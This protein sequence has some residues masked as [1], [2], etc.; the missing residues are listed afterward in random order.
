MQKW[1]KGLKKALKGIFSTE[2]ILS[3]VPGQI[4]C[5]DGEKVSYQQCWLLICE[6]VDPCLRDGRSEDGYLYDEDMTDVFCRYCMSSSGEYFVPL[7]KQN[8]VNFLRQRNQLRIDTE[9]LDRENQVFYVAG[10]T[11]AAK[12]VDLLTDMANAVEQGLDLADLAQTFAT[13]QASIE[14]RDGYLLQ[15]SD[16]LGQPYSNYTYLA[17][18]L[19][20]DLE[21]CGDVLWLQYDDGSYLPD[22]RELSGADAGGKIFYGDILTLVKSN[23]RRHLCEEYVQELFDDISEQKK[24][25]LSSGLDKYRAAIAATGAKGAEITSTP[26]LLT[27]FDTAREVYIA[28]SICCSTR[29]EMQMQYELFGDWCECDGKVELDLGYLAA[30]HYLE[31]GNIGCLYRR[32]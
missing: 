27:I 26:A 9:F 20:N 1:E 29:G 5:N 25:I 17:V 13:I 15:N 30:A 21:D 10:E 22:T 3:L 32:Y 18:N 28:P 16:S 19:S 14:G 6:K 11:S 31:N 23:W 7:A 4:F 12:L 8:M 24:E 2:E